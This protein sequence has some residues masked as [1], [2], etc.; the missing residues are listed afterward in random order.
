MMKIGIIGLGDI[1]T[2]AYLP[3]M[4]RKNLEVHLFTRNEKNLMTVAEQYRFQNRH[5]SL[6][7]LIHS[8]IKAAFVHTATSSH[9]E[10][11]EMLLH[12]NIHV[13]VDKPVTYDFDT[14]EKLVALA[15]KRGLTLMAGF[16]RRYAP[17]YLN[18]KQL[19]DPNMFVMQKNRA[20]LPGD[21]RGFIFDDFIHVVDTL[22]FLFS[23][24]VEKV[25][26]SGRKTAGLLN[27]VVVQLHSSDGTTAIG[28]MNRDSGTV[29]ERVEVFTPIEKWVVTNLTETTVFR[30][31]NATRKSTHDWESTLHKRGFEQIT[32]AFIQNILKGSSPHQL[33]QEILQTHELCEKIVHDLNAG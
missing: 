26:V 25:S 13:Y 32:E 1:A 11:V 30:Q 17:A 15:E 2:K 10:I 20:S 5:Q 29:E 18:L 14:T 7:S 31:G 19:K 8:G 4:G 3:V 21:V 22:L 9:L 12:S 33:H 24:S 16:N 23:P 6:D 28:I 27:H